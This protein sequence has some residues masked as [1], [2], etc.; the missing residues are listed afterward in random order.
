[1]TLLSKIAVSVERKIK[2][3]R[4]KQNYIK[5]RKPKSVSVK[6]KSGILERV[7]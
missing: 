7:I 1:M 3:L 4:E 2:E 5:T 6:Q